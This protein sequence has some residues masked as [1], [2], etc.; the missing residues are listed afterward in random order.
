MSTELRADGGAAAVVATAFMTR[1]AGGQR[2]LASLLHRVKR[3]AG[4]G[5]TSDARGA[6][7]MDC[8]GIAPG[9]ERAH[10]AQRILIVDDEANIV[11]SLEFLLKRAGFEA[12]AARVRGVAH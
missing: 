3:G 1:R 4:P 11:T 9:Q 2:T 10:V 7:M 6:A 8:S 5:A 12:A